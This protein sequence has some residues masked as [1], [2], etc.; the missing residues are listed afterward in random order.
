MNL[1]QFPQPSPVC[2]DIAIKSHSTVAK[3]PCLERKEND[4]LERKKFECETGKKE[5]LFHTDNRKYLALN[6]IE[7]IQ[8][9]F[10]H[11]LSEFSSDHFNL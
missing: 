5:N 3:L 7:E 9:S 8:T 4:V 10:V 2:D 11:G 1:A 6:T